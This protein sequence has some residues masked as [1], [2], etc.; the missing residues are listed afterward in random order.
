MDAHCLQCASM[1]L[2]RYLRTNPEGYARQR[3]VRSIFFQSAFRRKA[4]T[5]SQR[6]KAMLYSLALE[7]KRTRVARFINY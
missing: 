2:A 7:A 3:E 5:T 6:G 4:Q 1:I